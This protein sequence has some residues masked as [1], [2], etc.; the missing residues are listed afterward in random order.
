MARPG[1]AVGAAVVAVL[2]ILSFAPL[3]FVHPFRVSEFRPWLQ[4]SA[5]FWAISTLALLWPG[6]SPD[7]SRLWLWTSYAT[8]AALLGMG[9]IRTVRGDRKAAAQAPA[10]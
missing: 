6:W 4:V 9:L 5:L 10:G 7:L 3:R 2:A 8:A 1:E